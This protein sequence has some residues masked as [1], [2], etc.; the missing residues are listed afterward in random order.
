ML[1]P[2]KYPVAL[3]RTKHKGAVSFE[4]IRLT[5]LGSW[6]DIHTARCLAC[7]STGRWMLAFAEKPLQ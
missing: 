2:R 4:R 6:R 1:R 5:V 7:E 3:W